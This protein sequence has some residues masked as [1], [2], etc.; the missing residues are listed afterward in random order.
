M[1]DKTE[2]SE[3]LLDNE[4]T[5]QNDA[6]FTKRRLCIV[7]ICALY[8]FG[9]GILMYAVPEYIQSRVAEAVKSD[10][11]G[12]PET[13]GTD[14]GGDTKFNPCNSNESS[15]EYKLHTEI[16]QESA[17]WLI[18]VALCSYIPPLA[19]NLILGSYS[20]IKG[21]KLVFG[22]CTVG[23]TLRCVI[24]TFVVYFKANLLFLLLGQLL[25]GVTGSFTVYFAVS[26]SYLS[27]ITK[28]DRSRTVAI[29][30][31]DLVLG[32]TISVSSFASGYFIRAE[33]FMY[34]MLTAT[35][36]TAV[37]SICTLIFLPETL[38][39][40]G[41][42]ENNSCIENVKRSVKFYI[43]S[44]SQGRLKTC[45]YILLLLCFTFVAIPNMNRLTMETLYQLGRPFCWDPSKIGWFGT[46][47]IT[48]MSIFGIGA[49]F[50]LKKCFK[51]DSIAAIACVFGIASFIV[52]GLATTDVVLYTGMISYLERLRSMP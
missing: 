4:E 33:G 17:K 26:Y 20:D 38:P 49:V 32:L 12:R 19:T 52:E 48:C 51:D 2:D 42:S 29:V 30:L 31:F 5:F 34:P 23:N 47:K 9:Y 28:P 27:D 8:F 22:I 44:E 50:I 43:S 21:R 25:D 37:A 3:Q 15:P 11:H 7:P 39:R 40:R 18:Y 36:L 24:V 46:V 35:I 13:P 14:P 16:Q 10:W 6:G 45:K 41:L 1:M